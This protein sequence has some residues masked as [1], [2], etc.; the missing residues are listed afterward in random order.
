MWE[1]LLL[2]KTMGPGCSEKCRYKCKEHIPEEER[3][4]IF[5]SYWKIGDLSRQRQYIV[6]HIE[7]K[8]TAKPLMIANSRRQLTYSYTLQSDDET[9]TVCKTFFL[10]TLGVKEDVVYGA[11]NKKGRH[12]VVEP[13]MRGKHRKQR[14]V[15]VEAKNLI[16]KHIASFKTIPS[17]YCRKKSD[18]R[19]LPSELNIVKMYRMYKEI[20]VERNIHPEKEFVYRRIF[21]HEFNLFFY[22]P[23]KDQCDFCTEYRNTQKKSR[24]LQQRYIRHQEQ[25]VELARRAK[26]CVRNLDVDEN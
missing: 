18:R 10:H 26:S 4:N 21:N 13:D 22:I 24:E 7:R 14:S 5:E 11:F 15:S 1:N 19:Y 3:I 2:K 20:C 6:D 17:H 12:G 9:Y 23:K 8:I 25:K 16:R